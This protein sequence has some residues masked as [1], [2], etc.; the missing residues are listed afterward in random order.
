MKLTVKQLAQMMDLSAVRT[1]VDLDEVRG[2]AEACKRYGCICAFVMPCYMAK[3]K[4]LLADAPQVGLGGVVGFPSGAVSTTIK[5][6]EVHEHLELGVSELDMVINVGLLRSGRD[7]EAEDDIRAVVDAAQGTPV[8]VILEA[9]YLTDE[10]IVRGSQISVR[11]GAAFVKTGTGWAPTGA[12]LHNV[13]LMKSTVGDAAQ[14]KAAGGVRDL[15]TVV[16][17]IR[18]GVTR[19]GVGLSSGT[20]I[21]DECATLPDGIEV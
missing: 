11:A 17:M 14:V 15:Q 7:Q 16:E 13:A 4:E 3:L 2:L 1:D 8:K 19:F 20:A 12:T 5:V 9:H 10:E 18:A 21:L 6:A